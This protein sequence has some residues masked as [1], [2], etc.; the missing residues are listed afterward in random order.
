MN[1]S[2]TAARRQLD[3]SAAPVVHAIPLESPGEWRAALEGIPHSFF[4]TWEH[5]YAMHLTHK[6]PA[7]LYCA[8]SEGV[9]VVCPFI[10]RPLGGY[11]DIAT[12]YG[13]SGFAGNG[14]LAALPELWRSFATARG[15]ISVFLNLHP[16]FFRPDY[17]DPATL[18]EQK[19]LYIF[20]ATAGLE[21]LF[22]NLARSRRRDLRKWETRTG[23][24]TDRDELRSFVLEHYRQFYRWKNA[25][26][27]YDFSSRTME[28][29]L[30]QE[31]LLLLGAGADSG[32]ESVIVIAVTDYAAEGLFYFELPGTSRFST[33]L[34]WEALA[35]VH[36]KGIPSLNL[37]GGLSRNDQLAQFKGLFGATPQM[38]YAVKQVLAPERYAELCDRCGGNPDD[39]QGYFPAYRAPHTEVSASTPASSSDHRTNAV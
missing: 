22:E 9:R 33:A 14:P 20:D 30:Q 21:T 6:Q 4:H 36:R 8:E 16:L 38:C 35:E 25:S 7:Y 34:I 12:P 27:V 1:S 24:R 19:E 26:A 37:G 15:Y 5:S 18:F 3:E 32:V 13:F 39:R 11:V 28:F 31:N 23:L 10:E 17:A 2:L 29:L